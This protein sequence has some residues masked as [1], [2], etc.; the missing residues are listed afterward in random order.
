MC[1]INLL[2]PLHFKAS[3]E[4]CVA[5]MSKKWKLGEWFLYSDEA[6]VHSVQSLCE[7]LD[8]NKLTVISH[9]PYLPDIVLCDSFFS[10]TQDGVKQKEI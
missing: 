3:T 9:S 8:N 2:L 7:F 6:P 10:Q 5:K 1:I 4:K